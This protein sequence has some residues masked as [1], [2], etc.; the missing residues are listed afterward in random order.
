[1]IN[2]DFNDLLLQMINAALQGGEAVLKV[3][4]SDFKVDFKEDN[5]PLTLADRN[6]HEI[7]EK[8]LQNTG[9]PILS[10]EGKEIPY[11]KRASWEYF[12]LIDPLD[13]TKEFIKRNGE[14]TVNIA[15]IHKN[16][17]V[18][19]VIYVPVI[20]DL[21]FSD[22][23]YS[24]KKENISKKIKN[25]TNL[26][27]SSIKLPFYKKRKDF[28]IVGS[29]SHMSVETQDFFTQKKKEHKNINI[30][31][32]GSSL[33]FCMIAEGRADVY[34]RYAPTMEW[35]TGAGDS[36]CRNAGFSVTQYNSNDP[37]VYN[38]PNLLNP[39]FLVE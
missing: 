36:I 27:S 11:E 12:W 2:M 38:K 9:I 23:K 5:S 39:W 7:I 25:I 28:T 37:V 24:Y 21:Y 26:I 32:A 18:M 13:G 6:C 14:F 34:P 22:I 1:M 33:K 31:S 3:Y 8:I 4:N 35:D 19:G 29:R 30:I 10:E 15:L 17:P 20:K 16:S